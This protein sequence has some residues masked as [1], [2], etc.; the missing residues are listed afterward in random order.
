MCI[1]DRPDPSAG[2]GELSCPCP[3]LLGALGPPGHPSAAEVPIDAR[4]EPR[5]AHRHPRVGAQ[6]GGDDSDEVDDT[7]GTGPYGHGYGLVAE[8][9]LFPHQGGHVPD[10]AELGLPRDPVSY[11]HLRAHETVLDI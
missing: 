11:T 8:R 3:P 5:P 2:R 4:L 6:A 1:R 10:H 9:V 7:A